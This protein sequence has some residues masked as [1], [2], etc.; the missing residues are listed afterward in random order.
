MSD[1]AHREIPALDLATQTGQEKVKRA[2]QRASKE[3]IKGLLD[4]GLGNGIAR[5][6]TSFGVVGFVCFMYWSESG[7][8]RQDLQDYLREAK[9]ERNRNDLMWNLA[10]ERQEADRVAN[11]RKHVEMLTAVG[12]TQQSIESS[13]RT[14]DKAVAV[15]QDAIRILGTKQ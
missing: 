5:V 11:E 9:E 2:V 14:L 3:N 15:M 8:R 6:L 7:N 13:Q 4:L 12:K 10:R 1:E